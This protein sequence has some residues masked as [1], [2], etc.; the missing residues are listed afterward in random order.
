MSLVLI[1]EDTLKK[2]LDGIEK[3]AAELRVISFVVCEMQDEKQED[4]RHDM[5]QET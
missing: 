4:I 3:M 5:E 1:D 2:L